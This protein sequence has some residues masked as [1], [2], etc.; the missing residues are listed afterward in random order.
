MMVSRFLLL[1][2]F[3]VGYLGTSS[4]FLYQ[5]KQYV[6]AKGRLLCGTTPV[7]NVLVKLVDEDRGPDRDDEMARVRTNANGEFHLNGS[8]SEVGNIDPFL[9][10]YHDCNDGAQPCQRKMKLRV[11]DKYIHRGNGSETVDVGVLNLEVDVRK[12]ARDCAP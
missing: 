2:L 1:A 4:A 9:K 8:A 7:A 12:E 3:A 5:V 10:I 6:T 11:P